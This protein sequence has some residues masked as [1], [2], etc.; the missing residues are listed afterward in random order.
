[1]KIP[2]NLKPI[3]DEIIDE[4]DGTYFVWLKR[5]WAFEPSEDERSASHCMGMFENLADI[6]SQLRGVA[7][8][9][10]QYCAGVVD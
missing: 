2:A 6:K 7:K 9:P 8:C 1:M 4:E 3:V 10:C 5:G